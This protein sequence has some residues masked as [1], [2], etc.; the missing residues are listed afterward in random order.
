M[1]K[2]LTGTDRGLGGL[3]VN[4]DVDDVY[5]V[6]HITV[7]AATLVDNGGGH[8]T[9]TTGGGGGSGCTGLAQFGL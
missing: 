9:I 4:D 7:S 1:A 8:V 2:F 6:T 5:G 3:R